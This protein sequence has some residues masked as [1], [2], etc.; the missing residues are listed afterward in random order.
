MKTRAVRL[1]GINDMRIEEFELPAIKDDEILAKVITNSIC[2]SDHK[3]AA[4]GR[5]ISGFQRYR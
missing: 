3:A 2:M 1:Y 4:Q 5:T